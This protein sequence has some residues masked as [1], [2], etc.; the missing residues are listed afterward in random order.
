MSVQNR[1]RLCSL[2]LRKTEG[3]ASAFGE[4]LRL[5]QWPSV[6]YTDGDSK[7]H[8]SLFYYLGYG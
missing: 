5:D 7:E 2:L 1:V 3:W 8:F 4:T 6:F